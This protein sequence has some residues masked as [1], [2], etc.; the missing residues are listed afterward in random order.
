MLGYH[1]WGA[2]VTRLV[3]HL[4]TVTAPLGTNHP[5]CCSVHSVSKRTIVE[6]CKSR[7]RW[8]QNQ[9]CWK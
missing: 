1:H 6:R 9:M 7:E 4:P 5:I 3:R 2:L 8:R